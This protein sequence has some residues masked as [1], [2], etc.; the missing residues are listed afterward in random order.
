MCPVS[1]RTSLHLYQGFFVV[2]NYAVMHMWMVV[3]YNTSEE[4]EKECIW[5]TSVYLIYSV[6]LG[7]CKNEYMII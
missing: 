3:R 6:G 1:S 5:R 7:T 4:D 2:N